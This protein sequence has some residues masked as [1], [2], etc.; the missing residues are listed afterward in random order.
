MPDF[1]CDSCKAP[2]TMHGIL[3]GI[4]LRC[5]NC[6]GPVTAPPRPLQ[7]GGK[8]LVEAFVKRRATALEKHGYF[9]CWEIEVPNGLGGDLIIAPDYAIRPFPQEEV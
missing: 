6:G 7:P 8:V 4:S 1:I 9:D 5:P 3:F 2:L